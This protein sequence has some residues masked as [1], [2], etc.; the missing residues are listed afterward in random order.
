M[1]ISDSPDTVQLDERVFRTGL[2]GGPL[3]LSENIP[4]VRSVAVGVW[5]RWGASHDPDEKMGGSHLLEHMIFKG[6]ETR[7][8]REIALGIEGIGGALD[9]Y[10]SREHTA[11]H[12]R[13]LDE[14]LPIAVDILTDLMFRPLLRESDLEVER[15]VI[16]EEIAGVLDAPEELVFDLHARSLWGEHPYG[17]PVLGTKDTVKAMTRDDVLAL[18][19]ASYKPASCVVASA[20]SVQHEEFLDLI[21][22]YFPTDAGRA[23]APNLRK[24]SG[25]E[26]SQDIHE[27]ESA[28]VHTCVGATTFPRS[29]PRRYASILV[30]TALGGGMSSRLFQRVREELGL[31]Y[32]VYSFQSFYALGGLAG[33]YMATRPDTADQAVEEVCAE[34]GSLAG[35]GLDRD[36]LNSVKNQTKGQVILSLESTSARLQR[37]AGIALYDEPYL[38]LDEICARIDAVTEHTVAEV[39]REYYAPDRQTIVRLGPGVQ[40]P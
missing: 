4:G 40:T 11:C 1:P 28:Q 19:R 13:V 7:S 32:T 25:A 37:L 33:V 15:N 12:A 39:C 14:H 18:W 16:L 5:I 2:K 22:Q 24:P 34:L 23:V 36:E 17:Y 30:S 9:A 8:A 3:V 35:S 6:T 27:R 31:A 10:T 29:D 21:H 20:G 26:P 38:T